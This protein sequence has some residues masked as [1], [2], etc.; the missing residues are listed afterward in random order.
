LPN[1]SSVLALR[2]LCLCFNGLP[3]LEK[4]FSQDMLFTPLEK[5]LLSWV[6]GPSRRSLRLSLQ[7]KPLP[8]FATLSAF[9]PITPHEVFSD[10]PQGFQILSSLA[11][12]GLHHPPV[13]LTFFANLSSTISLRSNVSRT[14]FSSQKPLSPYGSKASYLC[15]PLLLA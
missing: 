1:H 4:L 10:G 5:A 11:F 3:P 15:E 9:L 14:I 7:K 2:S 6:S 13:C 12:D 8:S